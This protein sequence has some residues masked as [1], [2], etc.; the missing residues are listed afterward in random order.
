MKIE[1]SK[2]KRFDARIMTEQTADGS[3]LIQLND[4]KRKLSRMAADFEGLAFIASEE[5]GLHFEGYTA[6]RSISRLDKS[7][8]QL[9]LYKE[10]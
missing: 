2:G 7:T 10:G 8:V 4:Q 5:T 1:T 3:L 6:L 9:R